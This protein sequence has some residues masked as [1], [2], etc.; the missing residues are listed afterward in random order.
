MGQRTKWI[1]HQR[2]IQVAKKH[3]K[4]CSR[5]MSSGKCRLRWIVRYYHTTVSMAKLQNTD[6]IKCCWGWG[7]I[8]LS[9]SSLVGMKMVQP[10]WKTVCQF[11]TKLNILLPCDSAVTLLGIYSKGV[12]NLFPHRKQHMDFIASLFII[13]K[14]WK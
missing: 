7:T 2:Y 9:F 5:R 10:L 6:N 3:I 14:I 13:A 1:H 4:R 8:G 12:Q 11:L